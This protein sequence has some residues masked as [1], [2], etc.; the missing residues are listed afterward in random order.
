MPCRLHSN[1]INV[2]KRRH[3][4]K[5]TRDDT[6]TITFLLLSYTNY[7]HRRIRCFSRW[8]F[9]RYSSRDHHGKIPK[10]RQEC[11]VRG[12]LVT[13][14]YRDAVQSN[15]NFPNP[16]Q[17]HDNTKRNYIPEIIKATNVYISSIYAF[18]SAAVASNGMG[19]EIFP[20]N[21]RRKVPFVAPLQCI[22]CISSSPRKKMCEGK[23]SKYGDA[24]NLLSH[25]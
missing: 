20:R 18:K 19:R 22:C 25:S 24:K 6:Y 4:T 2:P 13:V 11:N 3:E 10:L 7:M 17:Y 23:S 1:S 9:K 15:I 5:E 12:V 14:A 21:E 16:R 8:N